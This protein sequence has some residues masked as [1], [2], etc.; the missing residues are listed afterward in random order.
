LGGSDPL[1]IASL[2]VEGS[3]DGTDWVRLPGA[4]APL[5]DIRGLV[6]HAAEARMGVLLPTP[7]LLRAVRLSCR[8]FEW[9]VG[10][11]AIYGP[12]PAGT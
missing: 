4:L 12:P 10:D 8:A 2:V 1:A 9:H 3:P 6:E 11:L 7:H 5:P